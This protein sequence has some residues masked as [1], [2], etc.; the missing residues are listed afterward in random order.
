MN[1]YFRYFAMIGAALALGLG[2]FFAGQ[3]KPDN[4]KIFMGVGGDPRMRLCDSP[5]NAEL[6]QADVLSKLNIATPL[7]LTDA[8]RALYRL[9]VLRGAGQESLTVTFKTPKS[10]TNSVDIARWADGAL[11]Q[12]R[13]DLDVN[14]AATLI[15][16]IKEAKIWDEVKPT[17]ETLARSGG[18][19]AVIEVQAPGVQRCVTTRY[20]DERVKPLLSL[21]VE[22]IDPKIAPLSIAGLRSAD[23]SFLGP[24]QTAPAQQGQ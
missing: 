9:S 14:A 20:D 12:T 8:D 4:S 21:F 1:P 2:I 7:V 24:G 17:M 10:G 15:F 22:K 3:M 13:A 11:T 23:R 5:A 18:G 19:S 6:A 16:A